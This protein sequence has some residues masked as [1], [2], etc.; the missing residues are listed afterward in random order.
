MSETNTK[1]AWVPVSNLNWFQDQL[2]KL[3]L[4]GVKLGLADKTLEMEITDERKQMQIGEGPIT[5]ES[6]PNPSAIFA[7]FAKVLIVGEAPRL[8]GWSFVAR[9]E[10]VG[11]VNLVHTYP[12]AVGIPQAYWTAAPNCDHCKHNRLRKDTFIVVNEAGEFKQVGSSCIKDFLGHDLPS[13][14]IAWISAL[15]NDPDDWMDKM[16]RPEPEYDL[17]SVIGKTLAVIRECGWR[18]SSKTYDEGGVATKDIVDYQLN[19]QHDQKEHIQTT[20]EDR[21]KAVLVIKWACEIVP[22]EN[23]YMMN[24]KA[25]AENG[26]TTHKGYG[27]TC[28]MPIAYDKAMDIERERKE[29][30]SIDRKHVGEIKVR[31]D[32][33]L[34]LIRIRYVEGMYGTTAIHAFED[35]DR[36][37]LTWFASNGSDMKEGGIYK[38]KATVKNHDSY[39]DTPQTIVNR[40]KVIETISEPEVE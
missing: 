8:K 38:V 1:E 14:F 28:S 2:D 5:F 10:H 9:I 18:S 12:G 29:R 22:D 34:T 24:L 20:T 7:T 40:V 26:F 23:N 30:A 15:A 3:N 36:N 33:T 6:A 35:Q 16:P 37:Y 39:K 21:D 11:T 19:C 31:S 32:F 4:R 13:G 17:V 25:L 27:L